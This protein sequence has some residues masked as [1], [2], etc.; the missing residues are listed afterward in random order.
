[1]EVCSTNKSKFLDKYLDW[2]IAI[3][4]VEL[5]RSDE[6]CIQKLS[7]WLLA[8]VS[9]FYLSKLSKRRRLA[10]FS[11]VSMTLMG[12]PY[13]MLLNSKLPLK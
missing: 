3:E 6:Q 7:V 12:T 1:M 5:L 8:D 9:R 11:Q 10:A 2:I 13:S 4:T